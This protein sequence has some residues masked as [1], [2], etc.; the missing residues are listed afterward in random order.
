[1]GAATQRVAEAFGSDCNESDYSGASRFWG[2]AKRKQIAGKV[3][4]HA[5]LVRPDP[6]L[7]AAVRIH[8]VFECLRL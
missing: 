3:K 6:S 7:R 8:S 5:A 1:M 4:S 2:F